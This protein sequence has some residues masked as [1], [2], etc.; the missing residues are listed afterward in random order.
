MQ[1]T[2]SLSP[3]AIAMEALIWSFHGTIPDVSRDVWRREE[4]G[5]EEKAK[6]RGVNSGF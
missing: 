3:E 5:E 4:E 6:L 1:E 2:A